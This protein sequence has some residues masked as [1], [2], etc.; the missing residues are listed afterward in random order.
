M[1]PYSTTKSTNETFDAESMRLEFSKELTR[2]G[3]KAAIG[4][5]GFTDSERYTTPKLISHQ[6]GRPDRNGRR[7]IREQLDAAATPARG[8]CAGTQA[9]ACGI[10]RCAKQGRSTGALSQRRQ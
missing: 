9:A 1:K 6:P 3:G 10:D 7:L 4:Q 8:R 5:H 2:P